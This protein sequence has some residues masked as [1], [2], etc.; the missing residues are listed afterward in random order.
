M[1][2]D[3][4][5]APLALGYLGRHPPE[6]A[7]NERETVRAV[8]T[9]ALYNRRELRA[10]LA[11]RHTLASADDAEVVI[12]LYEER[13][14]QCVK[15]LRGAFALVLWDARRQRMLLARDH[16][17]LQPLYYA[18][19]H[20]RLAASGVLRAL[21]R[22]PGVGDAWDPS[23]LDA[24]LTLGHVP[25]P[26]TFYPGVRQLR[27]GEMAVWESGR[28][29]TQQYWQLTFPER[30]M[31]R[32]DF[33]ALFRAQVLEALRL[34]QAGVV[35]ALL[36]SGGI[37]AAALLTL[38]V[39]EGRPPARTYTVRTG[40]DAD[41]SATAAAIAAT[42][43][44]DHVVIEEPADWTAALDALLAA[45][46]GPLGSIEA[47]LLGLAAGRAASDGLGVL[48]AGIGGEAVF[49]GSAPARHFE[50]L[51]RYR[52]LPGLAREGAE[53]LARFAPRG[54]GHSLRR[55]IAEQ[56]LAPLETYTRAISLLTPDERAELLTEDARAAIGEPRP[57]AALAELFADAVA[58]GADDSADVIHY[59]ELAFRLP[60]R[61]V[62]AAAA[63]APLELRLPLCDHR[64]AQFVASVPAAERGVGGDRQ[65]LLRAAVESLVPAALLKAP[66][67]PLVPSRA[68]WSAGGLR[69]LVEE[70]L[71]RTRLAGQGVFQPDTV[72]RLWREHRE[73]VRD[74][75]SSLWAIVATT[76]WL[77]RRPLL[78]T[79]RVSATA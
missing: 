11:G 1:G 24:L 42:A 56:R 10:S 66:H 64:L 21:A 38:A 36:L 26:A 76:R 45:A 28:L 29:R 2:A 12:H 4:R 68:A 53:M 37:D 73:G 8:L 5:G 7:A 55:V 49:G 71:D 75:A 44:M 23:A 13:G 16:L 72:A 39:S 65:R 17:G 78:E 6:V 60:A 57:W 74:H 41:E 9:G 70:T 51:R 47:P 22:L 69:T 67:V 31:T 61:A 58:A 32:A 34:R 18:V 77:E 50:R 19:D 15:A 59:V 52:Q 20:E 27:P 35:S 63:T 25:P 48:L 43:R 40:G 14:I 54:W 30:R 3:G 33:P 79:P 62:A 46:G